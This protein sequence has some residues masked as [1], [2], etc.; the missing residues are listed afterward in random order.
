M[1]I[2]I[3]EASKTASHCASKIRASLLAN[4]WGLE[5]LDEQETFIKKQALGFHVLYREFLQY[6]IAPENAP[7]SV[8]AQA[9]GVATESICRMLDLSKDLP[10]KPEVRIDKM[11]VKRCREF[12]HPENIILLAKEMERALSAELEALQEEALS[13]HLFKKKP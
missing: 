13:P 4:K 9:L 11:V 8:R 2:D 12:Q 5:N 3:E 10:E 6:L 1:Q 7:F